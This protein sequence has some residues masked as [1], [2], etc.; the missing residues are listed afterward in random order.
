MIDPSS[1]V[2]CEH[3][4][5]CPGC[6]LID[7]TYGEQVEAKRA[8]VASLVARFSEL[9]R[10]RV[11][12][13]VP[14]DPVVGYRRRAKLAVSGC[15]IGLYARGSHRVVDLPRCRIQDPLVLRIVGLVRELAPPALGLCA[16]DVARA[17]DRALV[18][19]V[20]ED[21]ATDK[22]VREFATELASREP[23]IAGVAV[24]RRDPGSPRLL[25][26][27]PSLALGAERIER[28]VREP[29]PFGYSTYGA[30]AQA[31]AGQ[32][33]ALLDAVLGALERPGRARPRVLD[34]F[35][36]SGSLS[37]ALAQSGARVHAVEGF[38]AAADLVRKAAR[39]QGLDLFVEANDAERAV[40]RLAAEGERFDAVVLNPPRRGLSPLLR[41]SVVELGPETVVYVS[42][43]PRTLARDLADFARHGFSPVSLAP[44]DMMPLTEEVET[45]AVLVRAAPP[46][47]GVLFADDALIAVVKSPHE[48]TTPQGEHEG[49]LLARVRRLPGAERAVPVHRL[50]VGTSGV[51]LFARRPEHAEELGAALA[52]GRKEYMAL[53]LGV[54]RKKG[55]VNRSLVDQGE[56]REARTRYSRLD[57]VGGHSLV[58][59][60]PAQGRKHQV[61]RHLASI[62]HPVVGDDRYGNTR[63]NT[64]FSMKHG[65]DRPFLHAC[66]IT[67]MHAGKE[68]SLSAPL[69]PDLELVIESLGASR[70]STRDEE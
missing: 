10:C 60:H 28:R 4:K 11:A 61:R 3:S 63:T 24:S 55:V 14:A 15:A 70:T 25:G 66:S 37:L 69:A 26:R 43:E 64:H 42:C 50:D 32:E 44:Y 58:A 1:R 29:G 2:V 5:D 6:P 51:C 17:S 8:R 57:V 41:H 7:L 36:G 20:V 31:H 53:V 52:A 23:S 12:P 47:P 65:L 54:V 35:A 62:G 56:P 59:V 21:R 33:R 49:S 19:L 38:G 40:Q 18:T 67:L 16:L 13:V 30:F 68:L 27:A 39:D 34:V 46:E 48:P 22:V 9:A 45:L